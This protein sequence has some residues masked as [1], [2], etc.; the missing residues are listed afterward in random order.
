MTAT[1]NVTG[2]LVI[3]T[4]FAIGCSS[5][6]PD[7]PPQPVYEQGSLGANQGATQPL[8]AQPA[9]VGGAPVQPGQPNPG[10]PLTQMLGAL[11]QAAQGQQQQQNQPVQVQMVPWQNLAQALPVGAPGWSSSSPATGESAQAMG[12]SVSQA[13][14]ALT[15]GTMR[16]QVEIIDTSMNPLV[17]MPFNMART[18]KID[19]SEQRMGPINFGTYPGTLH[20]DK[21]SNTAEVMA[22]VNNRILITVKISGATSEAPA[23]GLAQYVNFGH[24]ASLTG[25]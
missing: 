10:L 2:P 15:Q 7:P 20:F 9:P 3:A 18:V 1:R 17:A 6:S 5:K 8:P 4:F 13:K 25:N 16:A 21:S 12:I 23:V 19:S 14:A 22:M 24:L 11:G